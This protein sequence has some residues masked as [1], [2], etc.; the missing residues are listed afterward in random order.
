MYR[1]FLLGLCLL[2][3][4][5]QAQSLQDYMENNPNWAND[6][7]E[8]LFVTLRC[9]A[10]TGLMHEYF[11]DDDKAS[12]ELLNAMDNTSKFFTRLSYGANKNRSKPMTELEL[13]R[14]NDVFTNLYIERMKQSK[15]EKNSV[16]TDL[17]KT[18]YR[19]CFHLKNKIA[20]AY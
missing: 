14:K 17:V 18:D 3:S 6:N 11:K 15:I 4:Q 19:I 13:I 16:F 12:A 2:S 20:Y 7:E 5:I 9:Q 1:S 8:V 10:V